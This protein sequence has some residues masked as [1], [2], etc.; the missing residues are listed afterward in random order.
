MI[1]FP[2]RL[3]SFVFAALALVAAA[4]AGEPAII[5]KARAFLGPETALDAV[6]SVHY[7][8]TV[9]SADA[10]DPTKVTRAQIEIIAQKPDQQ[11]VVAKSDKAIETTVLDGY[12]GWQRTQDAN[13]PKILRMTVFKPDAVRRLRAQVWENVSFF[14]GIE[15]R[16]GRIE[17]QGTKTI[18]GIECQKIAFIYAPNIIFYRY[19]DPATGRLVQTETEDGGITRE[20]GVTMV[21]GVRFPKTMQ[22]TLKGAKGQTQNVVVTLEKVTLNEVFPPAVFQMPSPGVE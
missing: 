21:N 5:A 12:E 20:E 15:Q 7:T 11:R 4:Q 8:G 1:S 3:P 22:M 6:K 17:E 13:S 9:V 19:F 16:G 10:A 14:R 2:V 18:D